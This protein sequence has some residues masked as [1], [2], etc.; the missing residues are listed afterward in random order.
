MDPQIVF[1]AL[2]IGL[3]AGMMS[4]LVGIGGGIIMVPALVFFLHYNQ[5]QAQG[6][7]L[8]VLT[9]PV[10]ML[11]AIQYYQY[12]KG[13]GTPIDLR[14]SGLIAIGFVAGS[15][16]GGRWAVALPQ[17]Q[18]KQIFAILLLYVAIRM[19]GWDQWIWQAL[20]KS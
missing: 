5:Y 11:A 20:K 13:Q 1:I 18:L 12:C 14:I 6:T 3:G 7:S 19:L 2:A 17:E 10:V 4:G 8:A 15:Y 16:W 9:L